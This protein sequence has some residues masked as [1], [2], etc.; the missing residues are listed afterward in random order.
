MLISSVK[1]VA[2]ALNSLINVTKAASGKPMDHPE[3]KR[4]KESAKVMVM[5][6]TSLLRT[7]K[8]IEDQTQQG[9]HALEITIESIGQQLH[10]YQ[11][12][13]RS[14]NV[15]ATPEDLISVT[16][17]VRRNGTKRNE[18]KPLFRSPRPRRRR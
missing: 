3:M 10:F 14:N 1:D 16:K 8:T 5:N 12:N 11:Q 15:G 17:Q 7:V 6:V 2:L 18:A 4:L 13:D 9:K